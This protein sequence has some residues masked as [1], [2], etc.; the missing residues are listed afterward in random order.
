LEKGLRDFAASNVVYQVGPHG[1]VASRHY[2]RDR[3]TYMSAVDLLNKV[4]S[5][6]FRPTR[7]LPGRGGAILEATWTVH[8]LEGLSS[9][10]LD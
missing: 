1:E 7:R 9:Q 4:T 6:C 3:F 2:G 10:R 8:V 5:I